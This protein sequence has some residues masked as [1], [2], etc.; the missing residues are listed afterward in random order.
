MIPKITIS[1]TEPLDILY[2]QFAE[3]GRPPGIRP[4]SIP[5]ESYKYGY[6]NR[7]KSISTDSGYFL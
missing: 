7:T 5:F 4:Q 6:E 3:H 1:N 2:K